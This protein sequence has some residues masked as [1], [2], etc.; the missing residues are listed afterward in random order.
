[1]ILLTL[2]HRKVDSTLACLSIYDTLLSEGFSMCYSLA[3]FTRNLTKSMNQDRFGAVL[4]WCGLKNSQFLWQ[5]VKSNNAP[6]YK[7]PRTEDSTAAASVISSKA[8]TLNWHLLT[9]LLR[10]LTFSN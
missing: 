5:D 7:D 1:M 6:P 8:F 4:V 2:E 9:N 10:T 3:F